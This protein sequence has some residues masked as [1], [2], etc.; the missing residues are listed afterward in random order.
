M[1]EAEEE[2]AVVM[3]YRKRDKAGEVDAGCSDSCSTRA[4]PKQ[5]RRI[6]VWYH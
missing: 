6:A 5:D 3:V 1:L 2:D 4:H